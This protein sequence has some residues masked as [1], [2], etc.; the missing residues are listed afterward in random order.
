MG[1]IL[2]NKSLGIFIDDIIVSIN[3]KKYRFGRLYKG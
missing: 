3:S 2:E 1:H